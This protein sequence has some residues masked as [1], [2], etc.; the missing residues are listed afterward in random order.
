MVTHSNVQAAKEPLFLNRLQHPNPSNGDTSVPVTKPV[1]AMIQDY[2]DNNLSLPMFS[3]DELIGMTVLH[4]IDEDVIHAKVV[5]KIMDQDAEN[6][7]QIKFLLT[8]G[9]GQLE[10]IISYIEL[11]DLITESMS[12]KESGVKQKI[13]DYGKLTITL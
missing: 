6:H 1:I 3:P 7:S 11:S 5:S 12:A 4:T 2:F 10:E 13:N 9:N 8:L